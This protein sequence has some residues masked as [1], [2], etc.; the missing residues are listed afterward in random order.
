MGD[1]TRE[2]GAEIRRHLA[3]CEFCAAEAAFY[4]RY[5]VAAEDED[6]AEIEAATIPRPLYELAEALLKSRSDSSALDVLLLNE[7]L[8]S[9]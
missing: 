9:R 8:A 6:P 1:V 2:R 3:E 5:P 7:G 4:A